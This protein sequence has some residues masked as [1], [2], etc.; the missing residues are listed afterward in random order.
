M[1]CEG[2]EEEVERPHLSWGENGDDSA[3][4][5]KSTVKKAVAK[6]RI[7]AE[8]EPDVP[9]AVPEPKPAEGRSKRSSKARKASSVV[10]EDTNA[11]PVVTRRTRTRSK[12]KGPSDEPPM[13]H[14]PEKKTETKKKKKDK[15]FP[16]TFP[17][18]TPCF[19]LSSIDAAEK[20]EILQI[21]NLIGATMSKVN[22]FDPSCDALIAAKLLRSE[23]VL[24]CIG[25]GKLILKP[26]YLLRCREAGELIPVS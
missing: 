5:A 20:T 14:Q 10:N 1:P 22:H 13:G 16:K 9:A 17:T 2:V 7:I 25:A 24:G 12:S 26:E 18:K 6:P 21:M 4:T 15:H 3:A 8:P 11:E 23:K 19:A